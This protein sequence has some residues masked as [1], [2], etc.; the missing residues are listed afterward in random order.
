MSTSALECKIASSRVLKYQEIS[1]DIK[2][3]SGLIIEC[4]HV[5]LAEN[6]SFGLKN[7]PNVPGNSLTP[8]LRRV[9]SSRADWDPNQINAGEG[10]KLEK[11]EDVCVGFS[12]PYFKNEIKSRS[13]MQK[14]V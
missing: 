4:L 14:A 9:E 1:S 2:N 3:S 12:D 5:D 8:V 11:Y 10:Q 6:L 13:A 7:A